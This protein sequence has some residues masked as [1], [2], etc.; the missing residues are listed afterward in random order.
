LLFAGAEPLVQTRVISVPDASH[1][2]E[3]RRAVAALSLQLKLDETA[4]GR[5]AIVA[6]EL[7]ANLAKHGGGGQLLARA[8]ARGT[9][10]ELIAV[11]RGR[12]IDD[13]ARAMRD[14]YSSGGTPGKGLGAVQR[15]S[16]VFD[17]FTQPGQGTAV[18]S[19]MLRLAPTLPPASAED[20]LDLGVVCVPAP[21]ETLSGDA[22][23]VLEGERGPTIVVV[24]GLGHGAL[25]HEAAMR[26]LELATQQ[27]GSSP[28]AMLQA[29]HAGMRATRGAA[30][31]VA[32]ID[33]AARILRFAGVGNISCSVISAEGSRSLAS[34][35]GIVG[36][37]ARRVQEFTT[38]F[39]T[40]A[41]VV[42]F[43]DGITTRWR[44][45]QYA[46]LR[47]RHPA[48]G[49]AVVF[50]D[51]LRGRDDATVIVARMALPPEP[52]YAT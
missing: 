48:L 39:P 3:A 20:V 6:T 27:A 51:H 23:C 47:P 9:G 46:G 35:S 32:E 19:R 38:P 43:S 26:G 12:G 18:L 22:W 42:M 40:G 45:D 11:D 28:T 14:G 4:A 37:E 33:A 24:D 29:M 50:R 52:E 5:V 30:A 41:S 44:L 10:I 17:V 21:R 31:G 36:H 13:I 25:A 7:A 16:Q 1:V 15:M 34:L 49:A 2:G 8:S